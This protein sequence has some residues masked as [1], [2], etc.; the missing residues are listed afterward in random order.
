M[1]LYTYIE[2]CWCLDHFEV[3]LH[4]SHPCCP[5]QAEMLKQHRRQLSMSIYTSI[6]LETSSGFQVM[7]SLLELTDVVTFSVWIFMCFACAVE[8]SNCMFFGVFWFKYFLIF[9]E[10]FEDRHLWIPIYFYHHFWAEMRSTQKSEIKSRE[11]ES[12]AADFYTVI[13]CA[14]KSS[15][16]A[17]FEHVYTHK[18]F[19]E[20]NFITRSTQFT[21]S[22]TVYEVVE[23]VSNLTFN[24]FAVTYDALSSEVK[25]QCLLF[26]LRGILCRYSLSAL[27]FEHRVNK[28]SPRYILER[29]SK[30][31]KRRH[32]HIK[33]SHNKPLSE[34]RSRRFDNLV[35]RSQNICEFTSESKE[36]IVIL[37]RAYDNS[38][39]E[40]QEYKG[41]S[42]EN[43]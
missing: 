14:T 20:V 11:R 13:P 22:Y 40:M 26:E 41:K 27:S 33:S 24:K 1:N 16:E 8:V 39:V 19:R 37:H 43:C 38:M 42:K 23:K 4:H 5:N 36:L 21:L 15:I 7:M 31:V 32:T 9:S 28:V 2:R 30:N 10:L 34:R 35:F 12:D 17:Q 6:V 29:W 3:V 18:K 25:Y